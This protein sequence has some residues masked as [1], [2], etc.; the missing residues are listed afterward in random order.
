MQKEAE[1][2]EIVMLKMQKVA[3]KLAA[4]P[5]S[6]GLKTKHKQFWEEYF[7]QLQ[8]VAINMIAAVENFEETKIELPFTSA[9]FR[10]AWHDWQLYNFEDTGKWTSDVRSAKQLESLA[11]FCK[12]DAEAVKTLTYLINRGYNYVFKVN[13]DRPDA[14]DKPKTE[15]DDTEYQ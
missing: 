11:Y 5:V 15:L 4:M 8:E 13:F 10:Q 6:H 7:V 14:N 12:D 9:E 2:L 3:P 1:K